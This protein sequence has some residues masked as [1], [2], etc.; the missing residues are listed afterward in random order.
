VCCVV[1]QYDYRV[2]AVLSIGLSCLLAYC[3]NLSTYLVIGHTSPVSYQVT[4]NTTL[5]NKEQ[6]SY[7]G[8]WPGLIS[9]II[10]RSLALH[11]LGHAAPRIKSS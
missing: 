11:G 6:L 10:P 9:A 2:G 3:V 7:L 5:H 8:A 1:S 4:Y